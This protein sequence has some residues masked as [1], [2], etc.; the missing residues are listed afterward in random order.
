M[1]YR[2]S[3]FDHHRKGISAT[4]FLFLTAALFLN[5]CGSETYEQ[6]LDETAKYWAYVDLRN[7][8]LSNNWS[9][10]TV[11]LR[12]PIEFELINAPVSAPVANPEETES[13]N[14]EPEETIDPRQPDYIDLVLPGLEGAW[15]VEVPVDL[16]NETV[17][18]PGYLYVLSNHTLLKEKMMDEAFG[19][20]DE[21]NNQ[22]AGAFDEFL[23]MEDFKTEKYPKGR[24]YS[25]PKSYL[26]GTFEPETEINGALYQ[27]KLYLAESGNNKVVILLAL[28]KNISRGSKLDEH[29]DYSLETVEIVS[30]QSGGGRNNSSAGSSKF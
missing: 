12:A 5:G 19:F 30:P 2:L 14:P 6:R 16:E 28:P 7:Q 29:M 17:D 23:N 10:P 18:L 24:G 20:H 13:A 3:S 21:V 27:F 15:R 25:N 8:A 9:S 4:V 26:V 1:Q 22:I 11:N